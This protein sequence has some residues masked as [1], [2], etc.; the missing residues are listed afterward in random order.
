MGVIFSGDDQPLFKVAIV[1]DSTSQSSADEFPFLKTQHIEFVDFDDL[2]KAIAKVERHQ[3][4]LLI[5]VRSQN[6]TYWVNPSS[7][8]GYIVE[9]L[10]LASNGPP[11]HRELADGKRIRYVDWLIPG[12]LGMN[13]MF[14]CLFGI[15]YVIVYYRKSGYLKRLSAT[16]TTAFEFLIS[17]VGSRLILTMTTS[18]ILYT[19]TKFFIDFPMN[20]NYINLILVAFLGALSMTS[21]GLMFSA[22]LSSQELVSGLIN[23]VIWPMMVLSGVWFSLDGSP[24]I[25]QFAA[26]FFPLTHVITAARAI[27][28][29][30]ASFNE[31]HLHL[32]IL[33]L[34]STVFL[35]VGASLFK[36]TED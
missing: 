5:D 12:I 25:L 19:G 2:N 17:Q 32:M 29:D 27:M 26:E 1:S 21:M 36:W 14:S 15:G 28:I 22:R 31:I 9:K 30:G 24:Q 13:M 11:L 4:D 10:L 16:P 23:L 18:T 20:G 7:A 6:K 8:N 34:M 3:V 35:A 33:L